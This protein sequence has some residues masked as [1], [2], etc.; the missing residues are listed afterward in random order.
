MDFNYTPVA[1]PKLSVLFKEKNEN[2]ESKEEERYKG[3]NEENEKNEGNEG[4]EENEE[5]TKNAKNT[6]NEKNTFD[7][8]RIK[9]LLGNFLK[10]YSNIAGIIIL[11][12]ILFR[13]RKNIGR[14]LG[15]K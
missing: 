3:N 6:K 1:T 12:V 15:L 13:I 5:N 9:R 10:R 11:I 14:L 4:N 2:E 8:T 7:L